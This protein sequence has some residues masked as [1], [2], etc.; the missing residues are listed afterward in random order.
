MGNGALYGLTEL[1]H[2]VL[3]STLTILTGIET[4]VKKVDILSEN[5]KI[6]E[7]YVF[8]STRETLEEVVLPLNG[9][10]TI[11]PFA[12]SNRDNQRCEILAIKIF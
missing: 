12:F 4:N 7:E 5:L 10:E 9:L 2:L 3:P 8:A 6:I 1:E 11:T